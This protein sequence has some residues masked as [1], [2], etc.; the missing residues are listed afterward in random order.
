MSTPKGKPLGPAYD[1]RITIRVPSIQIHQPNRYPTLLFTVL[2]EGW[3]MEREERPWVNG[4]LSDMTSRPASPHGHPYSSMHNEDWLAHA[5]STTT[6]R[7]NISTLLHYT[8]TIN[9]SHFYTILNSSHFHT[10]H[11]STHFTRQPPQKTCNGP[12]GTTHPHTVNPTAPVDAILPLASTSRLR[13]TLS[14]TT[15]P[16]WGGILNASPTNHTQHIFPT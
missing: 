15:T 9:T 13:A 2:Q 10:F 5:Y 4:L 14:D 7:D 12:V 3:E 1:P 8:H 11:I 6:H 16:L